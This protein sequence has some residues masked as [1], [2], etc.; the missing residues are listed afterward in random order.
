MKSGASGPRAWAGILRTGAALLCGV[1]LGACQSPRDA[2]Q[3][4]AQEQGRSLETVRGGDFPLAL[5]APQRPPLNRPLRVY[6]EGD[7]HAW[8]TASQPSLDPSP[9]ELLVARLALDDPQPSAY[10]GRP[11]QFFA[12]EPCRPTLWTARRYAPEVLHS[13]DQALDGLK[14]RYGTTQFELIGYSGGATLALLLAATRS[15]VVQVQT[16]AGNLSPRLWSEMRHLTPLTGSLEPLDYRKRL[17]HLPQRH[18][19]GLDDRVVPPDLVQRYHRALGDA[20]CLSVIDF[21]GVSHDQ[22]WDAAWRQWREWPL[23][24]DP[25]RP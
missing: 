14:A 11:C 23:R 6:L 5:L 24:C 22:G 21:P 15:D 19:V 10:L 18:L 20:P 9:H 17:A 16:L 12:A 8:A 3:Q 7:G 13:L 4:M 25:Q 2:L 1:A